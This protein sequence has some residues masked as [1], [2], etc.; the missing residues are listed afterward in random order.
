MAE[1]RGEDQLW[2]DIEYDDP[3]DL[4]GKAEGCFSG[5]IHSH[6]DHNGRVAERSERQPFE[7][8]PQSAGHKSQRQHAAGEKAKNAWLDDIEAPEIFEEERHEAEAHV[9]IEWEEIA[10]CHTE[11]IERKWSYVESKAAVCVE[12]IDFHAYNHRRE[13]HS[14]DEQLPA[15]FRKKECAVKADRLDK[16]HGDIAVPDLLADVIGA[17]AVGEEICHSGDKEEYGHISHCEAVN[18]ALA[19]GIKD[20]EPDI[21]HN[22]AIDDASQEPC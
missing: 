16:A 17:V 1:R 5:G 11:N 22:Q 6:V 20:G 8:L 10:H 14:E 13:Y 15:D 19:G 21:I 18:H 3:C 4:N 9:H 12:F 7:N 2:Y